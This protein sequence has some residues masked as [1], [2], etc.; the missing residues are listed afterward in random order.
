M[1]DPILYFTFSSLCLLFTPDTGNCNIWTGTGKVG[2]G[3][4]NENQKIKT[5]MN[6][7]K[8][9]ACLREERQ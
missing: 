4:S 8:V 7:R 2:N 6:K 5:R 9:V 1:A 3:A